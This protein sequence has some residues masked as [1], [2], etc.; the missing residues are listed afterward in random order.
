MI[1]VKVEG[2]K[3]NILEDILALNLITL[4]ASITHNS[5]YKSNYN[6]PHTQLQPQT[7]N[8]HP[9]EI[10]WPIFSTLLVL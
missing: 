9:P 8:P 1:G 3:L 2:L 6:K 5:I 4:R 7:T 10:F